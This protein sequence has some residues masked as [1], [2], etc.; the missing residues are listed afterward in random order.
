MA[1]QHQQI[2]PSHALVHVEGEK[3]MIVSLRPMKMVEEVTFDYF[4]RDN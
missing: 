2:I 1:G 3:R 4:T